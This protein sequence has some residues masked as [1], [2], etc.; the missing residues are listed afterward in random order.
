Q[1][2]LDDDAGGDETIVL[3]LGAD[4][5]KPDPDTPKPVAGRTQSTAPTRHKR[6]VGLIGMNQ[7]GL[8]AADDEKLL[9]L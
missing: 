7:F 2:Y 9:V 1:L 3:A 4:A 8:L 6:L 5:M